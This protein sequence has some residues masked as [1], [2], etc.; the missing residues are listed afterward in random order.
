MASG[1]IVFAH[2]RAA[3]RF[4]YSERRCKGGSRLKK[5][6]WVWFDPR[7]DL[8]QWLLSGIG[9][10]IVEWAWLERELEEV[11]RILMDADIRLAR[12]INKGM[13]AKTR[14]LVARN[15]LQA[16][17][18]EQ[19][20]PPDMLTDFVSLGNRI[21]VTTQNNR[22]ML[23]HGL[24]DRRNGK[25]RV[26]RVSA[27][28]ATPQL[29]PELARLARAVLPSSEPITRTK[30]A[31]YIGEIIGDANAVEAF[32]QRLVVELPPSQHKRPQ[33]SRRR[34]PRRKARTRPGPHVSSR[35]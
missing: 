32:G 18:Y 8:P 2:G 6:D 7:T 30:L 35:G 11:I 21:T 34:Q 24:W 1:P 15:L 13:S 5:P 14:V 22:D 10:V 20:L 16:R 33:Y 31:S 19:Q 3:H 29:R 27:T 12:I 9:Q 25:W 23:A 28:R 4:A 26:L 17:I